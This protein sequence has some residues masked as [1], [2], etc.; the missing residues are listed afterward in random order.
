MPSVE[1]LAVL[2]D[3]VTEAGEVIKSAL[4]DAVAA[5]DVA[6][7]QVGVEKYREQVE[8]ISRAAEILGLGGLQTICVHVETNLDILKT[9]AITVDSQA[10]LEQWPKLVLGYLHAPKEGVYSREIAEHFHQPAWPIPLDDSAAIALEKELFAVSDG[11]AEVEQV[12]PRQTQA[13]PEDVVLEPAED[14]NPILL[15]AFLTEGPL[16][17]EQYSEIVQRV[18]S[19]EGWVDEINEARRL[20]HA[21]KGAANTVG[22]RGVATLTHHVEDILE[23]LANN[24]ITPEG[25]A[26]RLLVAVADCLEMQF[27]ALL[28]IGEAPSQALRV[29]QDVLNLAN[30]IDKGEFGAGGQAAAGMDTE[31]TPEVTVQAPI[32]EE[33]VSEPITPASPAPVQSADAPP[34]T[35]RKASKVAGENT[36]APSAI[37]VEPKVRVAAK[38]ID[39]MLRISGE[40]AISRAHIQE[41]LQQ[42]M[43][44]LAEMRERDNNMRSRATELESLVTT[45]G[46]AAGKRHAETAAVSGSNVVEAFDPLEMDQYGELHTHVHGFVETIADLQLLGTHLLDSL[47]EVETAVNQQTLLNNELHDLLMTSRMVSVATLENRLQRTVRQASDKSGKSAK[48]VIEGGDVM[49]DDQMVNVLIDPL[50]HVLRNAV[51][52]GLE[53][54]DARQQFGKPETGSIVMAFKRDGNYLVIKCRDDGAGLD[55][56]S[57]HSIAVDRGLVT[58]DQ[59]LSDDEIIRLIMKPGFSTSSEVTELSGRGVGMDIVN[60]SIMKMKGSI[61]IQTEAG[62][63]VE[64]TLRVPISMGIAHCLLASIGDQTFALPTDN[65]D[66]IVFNGTQ[67]VERIGK[68]WAYRDQEDTCSVYTLGQLVRYEA[69]GEFGQD[70]EIKPVV[71]FDDLSGK[72]AVVVDKVTS[73]RDLVIKGMGRYMVGMSGMVGASILGDGTVVPILELV[74]L[75]ARQRGETSPLAQKETT[76]SPTPA[77]M[78]HSN[79]ILVVDDSLSVRTALS[80]ALEGDGYAVRMAKDGLEAVEE[81]EHQLPAA[82]LVDMEMPRMNGLELTT[83]IRGNNA[84]K[85]VPIIMITSRT[86][87]KHRVRAKTAGVDHYLTKPY[88]ENDLLSLLRTTLSEEA[89]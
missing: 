76:T 89:A 32:I 60:T 15:D 62:K 63:G 34:T 26:A 84:W 88:Q 29:L 40:M 22:I 16:Q 37:K 85:H 64:F 74:D 83:H 43:R 73:G 1:V 87:E 46:V 27:E 61:D 39:G 8:R 11:A 81:I 42:S 12:A 14:I 31:E 2:A 72:I 49:L 80:L 5:I 53:S 44:S 70:D 59:N 86:A 68:K 56:F 57:I 75:L 55:L 33:P 78:T 17:A 71:L 18:T 30:I 41:R 65:L 77:A 23:Y 66:R 67:N 13:Q 19:S 3:E 47:A 10:V 58:E 52:H 6:A 25:E 24:A 4:A 51:D 38:D 35:V 28:G 21:L 45:Q 36:P 69:S 48:L 50:Q 9:G 82:V 79:D 7:F 54:P 20:I